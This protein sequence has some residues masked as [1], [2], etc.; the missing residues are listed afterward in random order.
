MGPKTAAGEKPA[1]FAMIVPE[2]GPPIGKDAFM[3]MR[4]M[5]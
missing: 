3:K 2:R 1:T 5:P 4:L